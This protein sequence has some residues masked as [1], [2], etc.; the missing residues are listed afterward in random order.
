VIVPVLAGCVL[1]SVQTQPAPEGRSLDQLIEQFRKDW[2]SQ[3]LTEDERARQALVR[4]GGPAAAPLA[5]EL[6]NPDPGIAG[7]AAFALGEIGEAA[8]PALAAT[9]EGGSDDARVPASHTLSRSA[10]VR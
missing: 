7:A 8:I 10:A 1:L 5:R 2:H 9:L 4:M 6:S 3:N